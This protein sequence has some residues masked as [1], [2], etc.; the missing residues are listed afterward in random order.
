MGQLPNRRHP[1]RLS[2]DVYRTERRPISL[3]IRAKEGSCPLIP[4][5]APAI[6]EVLHDRAQRFGLV[7]YGYCI[8][9]NHLHLMCS[10]ASEGSDFETFLKRFKS[11]VTRR[12]A[13]LGYVGF[14]WQRSYWDRHA[15][16]EEDVRAALQ[17]ILD[18]PVRKGLC[19]HWEE[20]PWTRF[21]GWP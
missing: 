14:R 10:A 18:N 12:A 8:M 9:P 15:R 3:S 11:E 21:L 5:L 20:W 17:Y 1:H 7:L 19:Q 6:I 4:D 2:S 16:V 13:R